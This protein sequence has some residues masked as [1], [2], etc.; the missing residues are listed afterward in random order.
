ME[1]NFNDCVS[2]SVFGCFCCCKNW[3]MERR[4]NML[5]MR[6]RNNKFLE[7]AAAAEWLEEC[8][9]PWLGTGNES[10]KWSSALAFP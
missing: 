4:G 2:V 6:W 7:C 10:E 5:P 1:K 9:L 8:G 3:S